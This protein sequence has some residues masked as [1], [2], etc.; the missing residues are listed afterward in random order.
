[1]K[2]K[3]NLLLLFVLVITFS[4]AQVIEKIEKKGY[5][6][7]F[8]DDSN[9]LITADN[10]KGLLL[11]N[12]T[13]NS[14]VILSSEFKSG[15]NAYSE[16]DNIYFTIK[17]G[18]VESDFNGNINR[19]IKSDVKF[20][21]K[22]TALL[23]LRSAKKSSGVTVLFVKSI[24]KLNNLEITYSNGSKVVVSPLVKG[25][26]YLKSQ[27]SPD[28][29]KILIKKYGG[30]GYVLDIK[31]NIVSDLGYMERPKWLDNSSIVYQLT[32]DNGDVILSS[33][34]YE[35]DVNSKEKVNLTASFEKIALDPDANSTGNQILFNTPEGEIYIIEK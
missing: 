13:T 31:G 16:R 7:L 2:L 29:K 21:A 32:T 3:I 4:N 11:Y 27:V 17:Q 9:L 26:R 24:N 14:E 30:N 34:I 35:I 25:T 33:D 23:Q 15:K 22:E 1:M 19:L 6:A 20:N 18:I 12:I 8:A 28:G 10:Y 5:H